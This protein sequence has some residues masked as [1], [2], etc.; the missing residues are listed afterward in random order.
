MQSYEIII[1]QKFPFPNALMVERIV[2][3]K[4]FHKSYQNCLHSIF[5]FE[6]FLSDSLNEGEISRGSVTVP[7]H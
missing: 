1:L 3:G 2:A 4:E 5:L 6:D 7:R